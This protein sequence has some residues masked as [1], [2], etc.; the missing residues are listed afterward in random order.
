MKFNLKL[1]I[2][3]T[4]QLWLLLGTGVMVIIVITLGMQRAQQITEQ[5]RLKDDLAN[6][7]N[8]LAG[9]EIDLLV[10]QQEQLQKQITLTTTEL[11]GIKN[12][13]AV[14]IDSINTDQKLLSLALDCNVVITDFSAEETYAGELA[15]VSCY[16][17]PVN[18]VVSGPQSNLI[19]FVTR[20]KANFA[21]CMVDSVEMTIPET[22]SEE[23]PSASIRLFIYT[24]KES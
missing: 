4:R 3:P 15:G 14:S 8:R 16:V 7:Q 1:K 18:T 6:V 12:Q 11:D 5:Q 2:K 23:Q 10:A 17:L 24:Y 20:L 22:S 13:V 19:N 21:T 9:L